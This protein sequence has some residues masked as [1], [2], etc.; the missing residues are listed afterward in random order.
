[1]AAQPAT[2]EHKP[3][4]LVWIK[5]PYPVLA[6]GLEK[7]LGAEAHVYRGIHPPTRV[8]F[9]S[10]VYCPNGEDVASE[11]RRLRDLVPDVPNIVFGLNVDPG[12]AKDAIR[13]GARGFIHAGMPPA[14]IV[15][16]LFL[17]SRGEVVI[18]REILQSFVVGEMLPNIKDLTVRQLEILKL[19]T[20][21]LTNAQIAQQLFLSEFTVKQHL[22]AAYKT[23]KVHNRTEAAKLFRSKDW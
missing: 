16:A 18:P 14:Q 15:R 8:D 22:R 3:L 1:M 23:L 21:G 12:L 6:L 4:G 5:C 2:L 10:I 7:I 17:A 11:I 13:A 9:S 20:E 19:I